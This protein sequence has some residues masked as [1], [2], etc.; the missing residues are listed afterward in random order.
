MSDKSKPAVESL[1]SE[2]DKIVSRIEAKI[3]SMR[4]DFFA[5]LAK[6]DEEIAT[7]KES[8]QELRA[9][10]SKLRNEVDEG[11]AY[12]R[13]DTLILSGDDL[14]PC[15]TGEVTA[16]ICCDLIK[17][18]IKVNLIPSDISIS[19]RIGKKPVSQGPDRRSI[20]VKLCR[21][22]VKTSLLDACRNL[23]P[24]NFYINE[25]LTV[26]RSR[27]MFVLRKMKREKDSRVTGAFSRDGRVF[28]WAKHSPGSPPGSKNIKI[29][30][31]TMTA[32]EDFSLQYMKKNLSYYLDNTSF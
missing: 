4:Q 17:E 10:V 30:V 22:D 8:V 16:N 11:E 29:Q 14:P 26:T 9:V 20:M 28:A 21:R 6:K 12:E 2:G 24:R 32:L 3:E 7:L 31:N 18:K 1:S 13:R 15:E 27:I 5:I 23:K 19:H 25:S